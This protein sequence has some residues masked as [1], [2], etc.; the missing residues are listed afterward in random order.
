MTYTLCKQLSPSLL[1]S[2]Q[3][4]SPSISQDASDSIIFLRSTLSTSTSSPSM[5]WLPFL[6]GISQCHP[7]GTEDGNSTQWSLGI[8]HVLRC[9]EYLKNVF[10]R[11]MSSSRT[12]NALFSTHFRLCHSGLF[13]TLTSLLSAK[14]PP[15]LA[16][17]AISPLHLVEAALTASKALVSLY[18]Y[19]PPLP[20]S[21]HFS[22]S[23]PPH[24]TSRHLTTL[25]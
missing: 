25:R 13:L 10:P 5:S 16:T 11:K 23:S 6:Q 20:T 3:Q 18:E 9:A 22:I 2:A 7:K 1:L 12:D 17:T 19:T 4:P 15:S 21:V 24:L 14:S 8:D